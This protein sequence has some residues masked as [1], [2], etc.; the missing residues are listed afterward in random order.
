VLRLARE[1]SNW[2]YQRI[3][4]ELRGLG[5]EISPSSVRAILSAAGIPPAPQRDGLSWR[6]FLR[7]QASAIVACDFLT[8]ETLWLQRIYILSFISL[9]RRRIEFV[10]AT[11]HPNSRWVTQQALATIA[12]NPSHLNSNAQSP[13][14]GIGPDFASIGCG[15]GA[16]VAT[17]RD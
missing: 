10:A 4:G 11:N 13:R 14:L 5:V 16:A 17:A 3:V 15:S 2:G 1:N 6:Q 12:R 9:E 7:Q 8:V